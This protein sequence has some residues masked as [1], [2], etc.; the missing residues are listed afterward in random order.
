[1]S[2][3]S[4]KKHTFHIEINAGETQ[5]IEVATSEYGLAAIT[6]LGILDYERKDDYQVVKIWVPDLV[7]A[8]YGPYFYAWDGFNQGQPEPSRK[9]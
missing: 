4:N 2:A 7:E 6:S 3:E 9:W 1:M 8:G 5:T